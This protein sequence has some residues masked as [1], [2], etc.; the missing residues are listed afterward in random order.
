MARLESAPQPDDSGA[1]AFRRFRYQAHVAFQF[2]L[3]CW[4]GDGVVAVCCERFEDV[5]VEYEG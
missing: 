4:T 3:A 2:C 1:D 5:F